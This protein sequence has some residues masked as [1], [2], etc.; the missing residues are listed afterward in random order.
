MDAS[1]EETDV[2]SF[3]VL[4][5]VA[6]GFRNYLKHEVPVAPEE[7]LIDKAQ[8]LTLTAPEMTVLVGGLRAL[9]ANTG[10]STH[11][12]LTDRPS[13]LTTDFFV[14][15]LDMATE[16][17]AASP[18]QDVFEGTRPRDRRGQ[19]ERD[20]RRSGLRV[21]LAAAGAG[22][23]LCLRRCFSEVRRRFR[24]G[25]DQGYERRPLRSCLRRRPQRGGH[26]KPDSPDLRRRSPQTQRRPKGRRS[27]F[28]GQSLL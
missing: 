19:V 20:P 3:A 11:G 18:Q 6:D 13:V 23:G 21:E 25:L 26:S 5:P 2:E 24:R 10:G 22:R 1:Q 27:P 16:W 17:K 12:V 28:R 14:N 8:L 9:G 7:L 15:L 4:E